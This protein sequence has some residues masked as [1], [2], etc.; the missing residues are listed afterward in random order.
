MEANNG[1]PNAGAPAPQ[2]QSQAAPVLPPAP[3]GIT[4]PGKTI[5]ETVPTPDGGYK[6]TEKTSVTTQIPPQ[7]QPRPYTG[8]YG[9]PGA[10]LTRPAPAP[11]SHGPAPDEQ[12]AAVKYLDDCCSNNDCVEWEVEVR[13]TD[14]LSWHGKAIRTGEIARWPILDFEA[15]R[16]R[17]QDKFGGG[18]YRLSLRDQFNRVRRT[19]NLN[20]STQSKPPKNPVDESEQEDPMKPQVQP[21][22]PAQPAKDDATKEM[23]EEMERKKLQ[24][25]MMK[26]E[27]ELELT[28][29]EIKEKKEDMK[30]KREQR[31]QTI[32]QVEALRE[33]MKQSKDS[34]ASVLQ[35]MQ[36]QTAQLLQ[37]MQQQ[38]QQSQQ[39]MQQMLASRSDGSKELLA[40]MQAKAEREEQQRQEQ[41][42]REE[43]QR[44]EQREREEKQREREEQLRREQAQRDEQNRRESRERDEANRKEERESNRAFMTMMMQMMAEGKKESIPQ[45]NMLMES[46]K[47]LNEGNKTFIQAVIETGKANKA[48]LAETQKANAA[49]V[50]RT[51]ATMMETQKGDAGKYERLMEALISNKLESNQ[52][53][54]TEYLQLQQSAEERAEKMFRMVSEMSGGGSDDEEPSAP[55]D[56]NQSLWNNLGNIVLAFLLS[57]SGSPEV[58]QGIAAA[59]GRSNPATLTQNDYRQVAQGLT[60]MVGQQMGMQVPPNMVPVPQ[61]PAQLPAPQQPPEPRWTPPEPNSSA[62]FPLPEAPNTQ[63]QRPRVAAP[64]PAAQQQSDRESA[65]RLRETLDEMIETACNDITDETREQSWVDYGTSYLPRQFLDKLVICLENQRLD[66]AVL[67]LRQNSSV[68]RFLRLEELVQQQSRY[69]AFMRGLIQMIQDHREAS[70]QSS[71]SASVPRVPDLMPQPASGPPA[72]AVMPSPPN[73]T[74]ANTIPPT[75]VSPDQGAPRVPPPPSY[76]PRGT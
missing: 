69:E 6:V 4:R 1:D 31:E 13:R 52:R 67:L 24:K 42:D 71:A 9:Q 70:A 54:F 55:V 29:E 14:P 27:A 53:S 45:M 50:E 76:P 11:V 63:G 65:D 18:R 34:V 3:A 64:P 2:E 36:A 47:A 66:A 22:Q 7:P 8:H 5:T 35:A 72:S 60:P 44:Q 20:L 37:M 32:P 39:Q 49:L 30:R 56:Q 73:V 41:R 28:A 10:A 46:I 25:E 38:N 68:D 48:D 12:E 17:I 74:N 40:V 26:Q 19:I 75:R 33:E 58:Q 43:K 21:P 62:P 51:F 23:R 15:T 16:K 59:L 57:K 61:Q